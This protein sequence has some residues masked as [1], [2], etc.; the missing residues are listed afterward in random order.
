[1]SL[2]DSDLATAQRKLDLLAAEGPMLRMPHAKYLGEKLY[3]LRLAVEEVNR[4]ITYTFDE[5]RKVITL[6]TFR[7]QRQNES[8]EVMR[9]RRALKRYRRSKEDDR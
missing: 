6:T 8:R 9:A 7:K 2:D 3:E 4:R 5:Q 1:M